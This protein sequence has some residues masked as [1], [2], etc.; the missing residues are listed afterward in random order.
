[1]STKRIAG[2]K[3]SGRA[4]EA[5]EASQMEKI[6]LM[7]AVEFMRVFVWSL[8]PRLFPTALKVLG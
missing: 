3:V 1:M 4:H 7:G 5:K 6:G 2:S 8:S